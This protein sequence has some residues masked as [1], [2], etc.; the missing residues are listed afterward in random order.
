MRKDLYDVIEDLDTLRLELL[1]QFKT[2]KAFI[3]SE[4]KDI[5]TN[6]RELFNLLDGIEYTQQRLLNRL[7]R[8]SDELTE[9]MRAKK[10]EE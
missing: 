3:A 2:N 4:L 9:I 5:Y 6:D 10:R 1:Y 7:N 8:V